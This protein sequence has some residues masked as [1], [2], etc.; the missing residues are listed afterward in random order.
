MVAGAL[1]V[2]A[3]GWYGFLRAAR[4][5]LPPEHR[6]DPDRRKEL[7]SR[8]ARLVGQGVGWI[9]VAVYLYLIVDHAPVEAFVFVFVVALPLSL[10]AATP[11]LLWVLW[12]DRRKRARAA[13]TASDPSGYLS[14]VPMQ[15]ALLT[16]GG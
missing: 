2:L 10:F 7:S 15:P 3:L 12:R 1:W 5:R 9:S 13:P 14:P 11:A 4:R 8:A 16:D 6:M